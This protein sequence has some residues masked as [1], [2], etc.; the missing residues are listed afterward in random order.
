MGNLF[1]TAELRAELRGH[2]TDYQD[3]S[4]FI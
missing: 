2:P 1:V 3:Q 4:N